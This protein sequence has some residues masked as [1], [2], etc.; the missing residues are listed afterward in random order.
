MKKSQ[1]SRIYSNMDATLVHATRPKARYHTTVSAG[2]RAEKS[3][4]TVKKWCQD[5]NKRKRMGAFKMGGEWKIPY[6]H[7]ERMIEHAQATGGSIF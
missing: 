7:F 2:E 1:P 5:P 3:E 6:E 4:E